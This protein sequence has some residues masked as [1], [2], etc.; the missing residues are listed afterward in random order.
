MEKRSRIDVGQGGG[1]EV[2]HRYIP[3]SSGFIDGLNIPIPKRKRN[4][5]P[6]P[7][8]R[9]LGGYAGTR[10]RIPPFAKLQRS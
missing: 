2:I 4:E 6:K 8:P 9:K 7:K 5:F 3:K 1:G 10:C